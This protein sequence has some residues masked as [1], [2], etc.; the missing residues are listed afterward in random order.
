VSP[1]FLQQL[2]GKGPL[3]Q[4]KD[5]VIMGNT[6]TS[7]SG[8]GESRSLFFSVFQ[9]L[10]VTSRLRP[11]R[12]SD[13]EGCLRAV[14]DLQAL[15]PRYAN[16]GAASASGGVFCSAVALR[17]PLNVRGFAWFERALSTR[18]FSIGDYQIG[19]ITV[20]F[21]SGYTDDAVVRYSALDGAAPFLQ[22][23]FAPQTLARRV[24]ELLD[25]P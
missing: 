15:Y 25:Q 6:K 2:E 7:S 16:F 11:L 22:K 19:R 21:M 8:P 10:D 9:L 23:P 17:E 5:G 20:L 3:R 4:E 13:P 12:E 14:R 24:R 18:S 1:R